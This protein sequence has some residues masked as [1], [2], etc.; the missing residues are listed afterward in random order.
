M[1]FCD[2]GDLRF[3][4]DWEAV[5]LHRLEPMTEVEFDRWLLSGPD[6][7]IRRLALRILDG[8]F[9]ADLEIEEPNGEPSRAFNVRASQARTL[10]AIGVMTKSPAGWRVVWPIM[11]MESFLDQSGRTVCAS[12]RTTAVGHE[13]AAS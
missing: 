9:D 13:E 12:F 2:E 6:S 1:F 3:S 11:C 5:H 7:A 8:R 4:I 10:S